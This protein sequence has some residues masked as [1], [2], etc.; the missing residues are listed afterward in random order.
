MDS[1]GDKK[2]THLFVILYTLTYSV[3]IEVVIS[4]TKIHQVHTCHPI[5]QL[6]VKKSAPQTNY[7]DFSTQGYIIHLIEVNIT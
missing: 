1:N 4:L 5:L 2:E 3:W 6:E 7:A